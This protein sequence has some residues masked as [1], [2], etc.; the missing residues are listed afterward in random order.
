MSEAP[1]QTPSSTPLK[2]TLSS[3]FKNFYAISDNPLAHTA[4]ADQF[5]PSATLI[6][7][8]KTAHGREEILTLRKSMW[9]KVASRKHTIEKIFPIEE[10]AD[11]VMLYGRVEY[12]MKEDE[13]EVCVEWAG[14]AV[15]EEGG[16]GVIRLRFYQVYMDTAAQK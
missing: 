16:D 7:A 10:N 6:M 5:T 14:R 9:E 2:P 12:V 11:E 8:S 15:V 1:F 3:F 4:Y 13:R